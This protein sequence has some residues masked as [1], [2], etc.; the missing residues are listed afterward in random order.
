LLPG[1]TVTEGTTVKDELII[2]GID[3]Q[4]VS[5]SAALINQ[6]VKIGRKDCRKFL[7]GI[8]VS[9]KTTIDEVEEEE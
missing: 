5:L 9:E 4:N 7:D 3:N 6:I 8:F 1:C 2:D